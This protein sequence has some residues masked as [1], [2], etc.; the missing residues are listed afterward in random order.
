MKGLQGEPAGPDDG[1]GGGFGS[2]ATRASPQ[3]R[4]CRLVKVIT[5]LGQ[6]V[7]RLKIRAC[8]KLLAASLKCP[9]LGPAKAFAKQQSLALMLLP[10]AVLMCLC[11]F[12]Q[13]RGELVSAQAAFTGV[14]NENAAGRAASLE[15]KGR[16]DNFCECFLPLVKRQ[17]V[18][19]QLLLAAR[20]VS[21]WGRL[22]AQALAQRPVRQSQAGKAPLCQA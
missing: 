11:L 16:G 3:R 19:W 13:G 21:G 10:S 12:E 22:G 1:N 4:A 20:W 6:Q 15:P 8:D 18:R 14:A 9:S 7:R 2:W 17:H 5:W